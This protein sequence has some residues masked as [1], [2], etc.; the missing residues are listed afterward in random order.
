MGG[1]GT[2]R[3]APHPVVLTVDAG[4]PREPTSQSALI[5]SIASPSASTLSPGASRLPPIASIASQ[6]APAPRPS[7]TRPPLS[8]SRLAAARAIT[9]GG[10]K[11]RLS[12]LGTTFTLFVRAATN[13]SN[14]QVSRNRDW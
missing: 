5:T 9:A 4:A 8:K 6:N 13:E 2:A 3:G 7:S 1:R 14:V 10:R 12:T 11:G